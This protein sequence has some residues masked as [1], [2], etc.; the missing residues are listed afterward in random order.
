[1]LPYISSFT[2]LNVGVGVEQVKCTEIKV[3]NIVMGNL[4][5]LRQ[6][7]RCQR[8]FLLYGMSYGCARLMSRHK[9]G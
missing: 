2:T 4:Y 8:T 1:M 7:E 6:A 9:V 5:H 3:D